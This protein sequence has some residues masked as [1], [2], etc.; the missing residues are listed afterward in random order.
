MDTSTTSDKAL[1]R[2]ATVLGGALVVAAIIFAVG[3]WLAMDR[4]AGRIETA[5]GDHGQQ[6]ASAGRNVKLG[7]DET[8]AALGQHAEAVRQAGVAIQHPQITVTEPIPVREPLKIRGVADDGALPV[9]ATLG[10]L[11]TETPRAAHVR[12]R[13]AWFEHRINRMRRDPYSPAFW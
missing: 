4:F 1:L 10:M 7:F 3:F 9:T 6:L 8:T 12:E 11:P 13:P 2:A 5:V